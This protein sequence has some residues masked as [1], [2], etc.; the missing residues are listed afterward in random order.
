MQKI[1]DMG[2]SL[3]FLTKQTLMSELI[4]RSFF[5]DQIKAAQIDMSRMSEIIKPQ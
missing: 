1:L 2:I 4:D 5:P 3:G